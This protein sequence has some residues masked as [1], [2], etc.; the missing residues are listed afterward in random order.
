MATYRR[1]FAQQVII[2]ADILIVVQHIKLFAGAELFMADTTCKTIEVKHL[3]TRF[4]NEIGGSN[5]L[6]AATTF[7]TITSEIRRKEENNE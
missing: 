6:A 1:R 5:A 4:P 7:G 3:I 2:F